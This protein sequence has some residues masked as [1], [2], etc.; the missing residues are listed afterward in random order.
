[1]RNSAMPPNE[2][3]LAALR[4]AL[5]LAAIPE[6]AEGMAAYMKSSMPFKGV[7]SPMVRQ[8]VRE[9][10]KTHPFNSLAELAGTCM[11][12]WN[13]AAHREERYAAIMLTDSRLGR[14]EQALLPFYT[15]VIETGQWWDFVDAVAP[16]IFELLQKDR[17][18][19]EPLLRQ[20]SQHN[21]LWFRRAAIISQLPAK[22][23]T[24]TQLLS[25]VI[26]VNTADKDFFI[27]KAIGWALRQYA[28]SDPDWVRGYVAAHENLSPLSRREALKHLG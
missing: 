19:M 5:D 6:K 21:N 2:G 23:A 15:L 17:T 10:A 11:T 27:R 20:W 3:F 14:G 26:A 8:S 18:L 9:L 13:D 1:M 12:L 22:N 28:R 16:R 4:P 25:D 7:P 24:D